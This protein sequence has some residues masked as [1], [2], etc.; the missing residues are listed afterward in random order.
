MI[1]IKDL[2]D[3]Y[4]EDQDHRPLFACLVW[5]VICVLLYVV[6]GIVLYRVLK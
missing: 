1:E 3:E 4:G 2:I 5:P 6:V